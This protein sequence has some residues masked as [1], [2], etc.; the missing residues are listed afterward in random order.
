MR[1]ASHPVSPFPVK[2]RLAA[3]PN[4]TTLPTLPTAAQPVTLL[5][6]SVS[7][8]GPD[9]TVVQQHCSLS[10]SNL[11]TTL[12]ITCAFTQ[13]KNIVSLRPPSSSFFSKT[14]IQESVFFFRQ[15]NRSARF[16]CISKNMLKQLH[17]LMFQN[18][19]IQNEVSLGGSPIIKV[20]LSP[21]LQGVLF[22]SCTID[23]YVN[24]PV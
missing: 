5:L 17:I 19:M 9:Q 24:I 12:Q 14:F 7:H 4:Q 2:S 22:W 1:L 3:P 10:K 21:P 6:Q 18:K 20:T 16:T 11:L 13:S 8:S 15:F 23:S